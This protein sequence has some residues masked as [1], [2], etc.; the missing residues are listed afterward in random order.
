RE[1][2]IP[3]LQDEVS[4]ILMQLGMEKVVIKV[5]LIDTN[6]LSEWGREIA[7]FHFSANPGNP[8]APVSKIASGG[9]LSR[10][11]LALKSLITKKNLLPTIILDEIDM[12]VSGEIAGKVGKLLNNMA[13]SMQLIAITH[14]PQ[15][16]GKAG[17][18]YKVFKKYADD[19]T[20]SAVMRLS[21]NDRVEEIAAMLSN[22]K[23]SEAAK[24]TAKELLQKS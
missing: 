4:A 2:V 19:R 6:E 10:L 21:D 5:M 15:I 20:V 1:A 23:V 12:G 8:P 9:E 22:E 16:A 13:D 14:L 24:E 11:M 18:H 3:A 17:E 7:E